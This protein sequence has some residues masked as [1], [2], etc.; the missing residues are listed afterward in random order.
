MKIPEQI[1]IV[2]FDN[3]TMSQLIC[4]ALTTVSQDM[5]LR[6]KIAIEKLNDLKEHKEI[7]TEV[8]LP[9]T[10]VVRDSVRKL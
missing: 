8:T 10:L 4:P 7:E 9:V 6:A 3:V 5:E 2:G 1:S